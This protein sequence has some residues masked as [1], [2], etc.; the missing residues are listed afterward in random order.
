VFQKSKK[1]QFL[2]SLHD[3][4]KDSIQKVGAIPVL[5][6]LQII[7]T[8]QK[9]NLELFWNKQIYSTPSIIVENVEDFSLDGCLCGD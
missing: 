2:R 5:K 4:C 8:V 7:S 1:S 6:L 3:Y 9:R